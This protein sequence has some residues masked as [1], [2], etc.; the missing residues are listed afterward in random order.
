MDNSIYTTKQFSLYLDSRKLDARKEFVLDWTSY[1][2]NGVGIGDVS[3]LELGKAPTTANYRGTPVDFISSD[4]VHWGTT[5]SGIRFGDKDTWEYNVPTSKVLIDSGRTCS[6]APN[7][8]Y[9]WI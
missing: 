4:K 1:S 5:I 8:F 7:H 2:G 9:Q 3:K 6:Y